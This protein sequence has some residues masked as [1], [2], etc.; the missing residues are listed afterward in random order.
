ML[1]SVILRLVQDSMLPFV[2]I[3]VIVYGKIQK[4]CTQEI[5][6]KK[7]FLQQ[8]NIKQTLSS[9]DS[10]LGPLNLVNVTTSLDICGAIVI[11]L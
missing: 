11:N 6:V 4:F 2:A 1:L 5:F 8:Q 9:V 3:L 7:Q 10:N